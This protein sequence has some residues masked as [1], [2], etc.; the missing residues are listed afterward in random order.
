MDRKSRLQWRLLAL[1]NTTRD[2]Q[3]SDAALKTAALHLRPTTLR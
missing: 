1:G 2:K 3:P